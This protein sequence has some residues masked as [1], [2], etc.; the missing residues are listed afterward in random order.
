MN[1]LPLKDKTTLN[2]VKKKKKKVKKE[3]IEWLAFDMI[4]NSIQFS[5]SQFKFT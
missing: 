3:T 4:S 1:T 2:G 5:K